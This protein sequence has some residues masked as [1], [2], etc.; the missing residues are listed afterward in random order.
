MKKL[1]KLTLAVSAAFGVSFAQY[2]RASKN[3]GSKDVK[4]PDYLLILG[5]KVE[6][7]EPCE[8]L[9]LRIN[10][11]ADFLRANPNTVAIPC[12]GIVHDGQ[13][14]SE[15]E[16]IAEG[17]VSQGI[18]R[19]RIILEDKSQTTYENFINAEK[20]ISSR[21]DIDT[22]KIAFL[23]SNFHLLRS[24]YIA[25]QTG[26]RADG[27]PAPS[28]KGLYPAAVLREYLVFPLLLMEI[29]RNSKESRN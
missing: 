28:P 9:K 18:D 2:V 19:S 8:M 12:G 6:G 1:S 17:L 27:V 3:A 13:S 29:R 24:S 4:N 16:A 14:I 7:T 21:G 11:A 15:A 23:S 10:A 22:A 20:I 5:C 26:L 25:K